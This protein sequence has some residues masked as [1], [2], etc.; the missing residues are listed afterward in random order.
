VIP[1]AAPSPTLTEKRKLGRP[2]IPDN[3]LEGS[4]NAWAA[5]L[6]ESW[7]E[8]G[9]NLLRIRRKRSGTI[10][11]I[12]KIF[13]P[14]SK[15]IHNPGL[16]EAFY[17]ESSEAANPAEAIKNRQGAG[18]LETDIHE[19]Q[20]KLTN[21]EWA[22]HEAVSALKD[23]SFSDQ[24]KIQAEGAIRSK[25]LLQLEA[26]LNKLQGDR[27][28]LEKRSR[29]QE[30]YVS[31]SELLDFLLSK[32]R[33]LTPRNLANAL[34]GLPNMRWRQSLVRCSGMPFNEARLDYRVFQV[35]AKISSRL[36]ESVTKPPVEFFRSELLKHPKKFGHAAQYLKDNWRDL[37]L[38]IE[39]V[40]KTKQE[41]GSIPFVIAS[42]FMRGATRQKDAAERVLADSE[43]LAG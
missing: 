23:A 43:K 7:A 40:W 31:R 10:E 25:R 9:W 11:D 32:R 27:D 30:A 29:D 21:Q 39:E 2:T 36:P 26:D 42:I 8:I 4:R 34:A 5:L 1:L 20:V 28:A 33:A 22:C 17:R 12:R 24:N 19:T 41:R 13:Q 37:R 14:V 15:R 3:F 16:A 35:V 6:E 38:A 18:K